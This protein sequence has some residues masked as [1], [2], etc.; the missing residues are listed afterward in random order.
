MLTLGASGFA[1]EKVDRKSGYSM[2]VASRL[3]E[4]GLS[5][6]IA[7]VVS[8]SGEFSAEEVNAAKFAAEYLKS[9][10]VFVGITAN[11]TKTI[12]WDTFMTLLGGA[13]FD[14]HPLESQ[15]GTELET[16]AFNQL[17]A[18]LSAKP[19]THFEIYAR[20]AIQFLLGINVVRY[21]QD[22][23]FEARPDG[24]ILSRQSFNAL[25]DAKAYSDSYP[26]DAD[27]IRQF[28]SYVREFQSR[29]SAQIPR[30]N[31]FIVVS[32][33]LNNRNRHCN[34]DLLNYSPSAECHCVS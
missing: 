8:E 3:D 11:G 10:P 13:V 7:F 26:V 30:V 15:F 27:S 1:I 2:F 12:E 20:N 31:S 21:G 6:K 18:G 24:I 16:L 5:H 33:L 9:Y 29:Y 14:K 22:R 19:D 23:L 34:L 32:V 17:P 4:F 25:Y 28:A